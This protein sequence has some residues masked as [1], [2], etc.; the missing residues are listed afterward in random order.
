MTS[1]DFSFSELTYLHPDPRSFLTSFV[2]PMGPCMP[3]MEGRRLDNGMGLA[4]SGSLKNFVNEIIREWAGEQKAKVILVAWT[5]SWPTAAMVEWE[6]EMMVR[7]KTRG[8]G[9]AQE[10]GNPLAVYAL[11]SFQCHS[12]LP[13]LSKWQQ[14]DNFPV[15]IAFFR[16][17]SLKSGR[18]SSSKRSCYSRKSWRTLTNP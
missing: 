3:M 15:E 16:A 7:R 11:R 17:T 1:S 5:R 9:R 8:R 14:T 4:R 13:N 2:Q 10:W 18:S 6:L 12:I